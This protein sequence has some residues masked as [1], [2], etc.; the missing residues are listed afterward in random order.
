VEPMIV[1]PYSPGFGK[2]P[3]VFVGREAQLARAAA[4]LTK[5]DNTRTSTG[6]AM[7]LVGLRGLGKTV[8]L[9]AVADDAA[10]R[11]FITAIAQLDRVSDVPQQ[12][13]EKVARA[14]APL[15]S[16]TREKLWRPFSERLKALSIELNA[17]IVKVTSGPP[18][19]STR[20]SRA[21]RRQLLTDV[22][23]EGTHLAVAHDQKGLALF[24]DE[25]QEARA[26]DLVVLTNAL[27][28]AGR[29][30]DTP[31]AVFGAGLVTTPDRLME[32]ASFAERFDYQRLAP[33][34]DDDALRALV[35]PALDHGVSW[36]SAAAERLLAEANGSP[37]LIQL[38][39]DEAWTIAAPERGRTITLA[40]AEQAAVQVQAALHDGM[41][42]GRWNKATPVERLLLTSMAVA[43][44]ESGLALMRHITALTG[45]TSPQLSTV[46]KS[47]IDKG[48]IEPAAHGQLQFSI[49]G[50]GAFVLEQ[51]GL[52]WAGPKVLDTGE[53]IPRLEV[54]R[55]T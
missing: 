18:T 23:V 46:R 26:D 30:A 44:N 45:R 17:G 10:A 27:Q 4:T 6:G 33:L 13:A 34:E 31:L 50:F 5:V 25:I 3:A 37:Y 41:F 35:Q 42:R 8:T 1:S 28:E 55:S 49:A 12:V 29:V 54:R 22:L 40:E 19:T 39:G 51:Q 38:L 53:P 24:L 9:G 36:E 48:I 52:E 15:E 14:V 2:R 32:S 7:V 20:E 21:S 47:L 16:A 11:G 43:A